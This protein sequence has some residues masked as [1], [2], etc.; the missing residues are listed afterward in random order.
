MHTY[1]L[2]N[3]H[4]S[5]PPTPSF[6]PSHPSIF[7]SFGF[8]FPSS[9][10]FYSIPSFPAVVVTAAA[11]YTTTTTTTTTSITTTTRHYYSLPLFIAFPLSASSFPFFIM[12]LPIRVIT[13]VN[14]SLSLSSLSSSKF[15]EAQ[16]KGQNRKQETGN[17]RGHG[18]C[19]CDCNTRPTRSIVSHFPPPSLPRFFTIL[20]SLPPSLS[21][22]EVHRFGVKAG[23]AV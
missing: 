17:K 2:Y 16:T 12:I 22:C 13:P 4:I 21:V 19:D 10:L 9:I 1:I 11:C 6:P 18:N 3:E 15:H 8:P 7:P 20:R 23:D 5:P 14:Q